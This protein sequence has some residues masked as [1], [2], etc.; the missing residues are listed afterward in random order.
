MNPVPL[1]LRQPGVRSQGEFVTESYCLYSKSARSDL[2]TVLP[3][4]ETSG[5]KP[6]CLAHSAHVPLSRTEQLNAFFP[7]CAVLFQM[8]PCRLFLHL[9]QT[10][11]TDENQ[12]GDPPA[13]QPIKA[14]VDL[15]PRLTRE[16]VSLPTSI[17]VNKIILHAVLLSISFGRY[18]CGDS[19]PCDPIEHSLEEN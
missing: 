13:E 17:R 18:F 7:P 9:F 2:S 3:L 12:R 6:P 11:T 14:A 1:T 10:W 15:P 5:G 4:T 8:R 19:S 16:L